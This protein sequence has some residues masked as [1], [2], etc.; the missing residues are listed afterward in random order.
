MRVVQFEDADGQALLV[1]AN[2]DYDEND[3]TDLAERIGV[4]FSAQP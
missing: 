1:N 4:T 2:G 3:L